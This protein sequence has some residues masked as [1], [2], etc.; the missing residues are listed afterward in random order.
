VFTERG[1]EPITGIRLE[2]DFKNQRG[3]ILSGNTRMEPGYYKGKVIKKIGQNTLLV[4]DGYFTTCDSIENPHFYFKASKMRIL[5]KKR[6]VAKPI[7][8]YIADIPIFAVPFGVFPMERGRRSGIII[9]TYGSSSYGGNY[10]RNFGFYW[11][12]SDYW[13]ATLLMNFFEKTGTAY[14]G[15]IRYA[16][17]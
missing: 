15:E 8:L 13:D 11:A 14:E 16:G 1:N 4:R 9:P 7:Y 2:Y 3:K 6:A 5:M 17:V 12:A 10:L